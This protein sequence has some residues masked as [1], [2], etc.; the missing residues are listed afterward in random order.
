VPGRGHAERALQASRRQEYWAADA[1]GSR[2]QQA[3]KV[4][5]RALFAGSQGGTVAP[6]T[7][8]TCGSVS[9]RL[10]LSS[11]PPDGIGVCLSAFRQETL[12]RCLRSARHWRSRYF[13]LRSGLRLGCCPE[14]LLAEHVRRLPYPMSSPLILQTVALCSASLK[15]IWGNKSLTLPLPILANLH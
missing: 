4:E 9:A 10:E 5:A 7:G 13:S 14:Q 15:R 11:L 12:W 3:G 8:S 2:A 6:P 1:R